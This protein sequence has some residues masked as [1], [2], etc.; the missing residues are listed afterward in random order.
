MP[1]SYKFYFIYLII[2]SKV[3]E[4][5]SLYVTMGCVLH[6]VGYISYM[7]YYNLLIH[8]LSNRWKKWNSGSIKRFRWKYVDAIRYNS[9]GT[10]IFMFVKTLKIYLAYN[11]TIFYF[12]TSSENH[13]GML[14]L[15]LDSR[16]DM[17]CWFIC[18]G[19]TRNPPLAV[20]FAKHI[21]QGSGTTRF[22]EKI[23]SCMFYHTWIQYVLQTNDS[24]Q[25]KIIQWQ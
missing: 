21:A 19:N 15:Y 17:R 7:I 23:Y 10:A 4:I 12:K 8:T 16:S 14:S 20:N 13:F 1:C 24:K 9:S 25:I 18:S 5:G 2:Y 11:I 22:Q 6:H 3:S